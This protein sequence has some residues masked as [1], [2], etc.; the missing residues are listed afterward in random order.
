MYILSHIFKTY[1]TG[2][3]FVVM[4]KQKYYTVVVKEKYRHL[5]FPL[6]NNKERKTRLTTDLKDYEYEFNFI[7]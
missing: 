6:P 4:G 5:Y 2:R 1:T 3:H 7:T